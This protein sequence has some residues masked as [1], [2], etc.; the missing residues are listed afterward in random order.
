MD[1]QKRPIFIC[2]SSAEND[3]VEEFRQNLDPLFHRT[4]L[5]VWED[6]E[7][8]TGKLW[9]EN[10]QRNIHSAAGV[11]VLVSPGLLKSEYVRTHELPALLGAAKAEGIRIYPA[12][13]KPSVVANVL[14][15]FSIKGKKHH[16]KLTEF[17]GLNSPEKPYSALTR[18]EREAAIP[19]WSTKIYADLNGESGLI[20]ATVDRQPI[21]GTATIHVAIE[22]MVRDSRYGKTV[23]KTR[24]LQVHC[25]EN[26]NL[27]LGDE[28]LIKPSRPYSKTKSH[29]FIKKTKSS[30]K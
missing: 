26:H 7:L 8:P 29:I 22:D 2:H 1:S 13:I 28:V 12:F 11:I 6:S 4:E 5:R 30:S 9:H 3:L 23:R 17:Q 14:F 27:K 10:I 16:Q 24:K 15:E 19:A 25:V 18:K 20:K 21:P